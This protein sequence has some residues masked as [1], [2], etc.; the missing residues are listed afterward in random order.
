MLFTVADADKEEALTLA[1][2]FNDLGFAIFATA[3]TGSYLAANALPVEIL[4]KISE[5]DNNSVVALRE[6]KLQIVINTTQAD[7]RAE[8]DGRLIRNAAIENAVPLFTALDTVKAFL[9][10]LESRSFTVKEMQ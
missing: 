1:Q 8:S 2:R 9:E 6:Q 10:V 7:E 4:D 3:G 5:S